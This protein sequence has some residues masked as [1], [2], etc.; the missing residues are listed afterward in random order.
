MPTSSPKK[1]HPAATPSPCSTASTLATSTTDEPA[2]CGLSQQRPYHV[3]RITAE[4]AG[5][6]VKVRGTSFLEPLKDTGD[7]L[8]HVEN[9]Q[10]IWVH[11]GGSTVVHFH[12]ASEIHVVMT[13]YNSPEK[14]PAT[15]P[16]ALVSP[17]RENPRSS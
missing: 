9:K 10:S 14:L 13:E 3:L 17:S 6:N 4:P 2:A 16:A 15:T 1:P 7:W 8:V 5:V 11:R 12:K